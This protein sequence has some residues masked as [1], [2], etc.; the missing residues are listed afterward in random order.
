VSNKDTYHLKQTVKK[1]LY[2]YYFKLRQW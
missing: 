2:T 1:L